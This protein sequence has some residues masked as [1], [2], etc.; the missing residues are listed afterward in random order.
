VTADSERARSF[1]FSVNYI[2]IVS[3]SCTFFD[4]DPNE[5]LG[6]NEVIT[7][8]SLGGVSGNFRMRILKGRL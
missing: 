5:L 6:G 8:S 1:Y 4:I 3:L 2:V 7:N